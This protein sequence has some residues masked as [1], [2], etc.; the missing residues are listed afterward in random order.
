[1]I[2]KRTVDHLGRVVIPAHIRKY[3]NI[4]PGNSVEVILAYDGDIRIR[5]SKDRCVICGMELNGQESPLEV[6]IG[7]DKKKLCKFCCH[8]A[9]VADKLQEEKSHD[10]N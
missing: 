10:Q 2:T 3:L 1:M 4:K 8:A 9:A 7:P 6:T 5:P